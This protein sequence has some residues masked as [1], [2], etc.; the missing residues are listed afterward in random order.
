MRT[1]TAIFFHEHTCNTHMSNME[2][3]V[4][5]LQTMLDAQ[6]EMIKSLTQTLR[7]VVRTRST[8]TTV[9]DTSED[10]SLT[11]V[12]RQRDHRPCKRTGKK[13]DHDAALLSIRRRF[14]I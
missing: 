7:E 2:D 14:A 1:H 5:R 8:R 3:T 13:A 10:E 4:S 6:S 12:T 11:V 9:S